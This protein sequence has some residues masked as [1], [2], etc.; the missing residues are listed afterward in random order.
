MDPRSLSRVALVVLV[1]CVD[2]S[3]PVSRA[4]AG[5]VT[6][7]RARDLATE[8]ARRAALQPVPHAQRERP[9]QVLTEGG[10]T[11]TLA[12]PLRVDV[13]GDDATPAEDVPDA[14]IAAATRGERGW[15]FITATAAYASATFT[16]RLRLLRSFA[17]EGDDGTR[18]IGARAAL[19]L[20]VSAGRVALT[21]LEHGTFWSDGQTLTALDVPG[22]VASAWR[23]VSRG[24]VIVSHRALK[25]TPDGGR[26]WRDVDVRGELPV[27]VAGSADGFT[28]TTDRGARRVDEE[29]LALVPAGPPAAEAPCPPDR[30]VEA[31]ASL[32]ERGYERAPS[33]TPEETC[34]RQ[35]ARRRNG[36]TPL[37]FDVALRGVHH[38]SSDD[39]D[40]APWRF[41]R[42]TAAPFGDPRARVFVDTALAPVVMRAMARW[43][44]RYAG[45]LQW[46]GHDAAG[47]F[48]GAATVRTPPKSPP[49]TPWRLLAATRRG[50]LVRLDA[51][52]PGARF[53]PDGAS[54]EVT[55]AALFWATPTGLRR[56]PFDPARSLEM[57][58]AVPDDRGGVVAFGL[59]ALELWEHCVPNSH[60]W[61]KEL[62]HAL[63]IGPDGALLGARVVVDQAAVRTVV[64]VGQRG[65]RWGLVVAERETPGALHLL[66]FEGGV[67]DFGLW[68]LEATPRVCDVAAGEVARLHVLFDADS[69]GSAGVFVGVRAENAQEPMALTRV[70]TLERAGESA[71]V[72]RVTGVQQVEDI[73]LSPENFR[74]AHGALHLDAN[75]GRLVGT[76]D[77]GRRVAPL[78]ATLAP[79]PR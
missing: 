51:L 49:E 60:V 10:V 26:T 54:P 32:Y 59:E 78:S 39:A 15:V 25:V 55:S 21:V 67:A 41:D 19:E 7:E 18:P 17:C 5:A 22:A 63:H 14:P 75:G 62:L 28:V 2:A 68:A 9:R 1:G 42:T 16:G 3:R 64:G 24:A 35:T 71:C 11:H 37:A 8:R 43:S 4:A 13:Q 69:D 76:Y 65:D 33:P 74:S 48:R 72:R 77:D 66:P 46:R 45:G 58:G 23:D 56:V 79:A 40:Y 34:A 73:E 70:V 47:Q 50:A 44:H 6:R 53:S 30:R 57:V 61:R 31:L 38:R 12:G 36:W 20:H 27:M 52:P 29:A